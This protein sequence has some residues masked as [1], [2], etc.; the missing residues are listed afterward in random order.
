MTSSLGFEKKTTGHERCL[1]WLLLEGT[2]WRR[3]ERGFELGPRQ[4]KANKVALQL[5]WAGGSSKNLL[6]F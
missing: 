3:G 1:S 2:R 5:F 6:V 4:Q